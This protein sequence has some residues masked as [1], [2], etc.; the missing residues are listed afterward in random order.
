MHRFIS[1]GRWKQIRGRIQRAWGKWTR[2]PCAEFFGEREIMEGK[3]AD[4]QARRTA[5]PHHRRPAVRRS[6]RHMATGAATRGN[7]AG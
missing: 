7:L 1:K 2:N 4:F 3:I 5:D 6:G